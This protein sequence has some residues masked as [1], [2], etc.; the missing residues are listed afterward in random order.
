MIQNREVKDSVMLY[1]R[2]RSE[3]IDVSSSTQVYCAL[4]H[5][6]IVQTDLFNL[7]CYYN[8][9]NVP[10]A[11]IE[12]WHGLRNFGETEPGKWEQASY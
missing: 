7:V 12:E 9:S 2:M 3:N 10:F 6:N 11:E 1:E 5:C 8:G 4:Y